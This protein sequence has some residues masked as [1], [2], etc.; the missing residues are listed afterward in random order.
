MK[1]LLT[2]SRDWKGFLPLFYCPVF[3]RQ[4]L[5][6]YTSRGMVLCTVIYGEQDRTPSQQE[7]TNFL[8]S[9]R[10]PTPLATT[11]LVAGT[12]AV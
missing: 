3:Q 10:F 12:V 7:E 2:V 4:G 6:G 8:P 9:E 11:I 5:P 1:R